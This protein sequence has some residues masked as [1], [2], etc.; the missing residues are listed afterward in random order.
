VADKSSQIVLAALSQAA[1]HADG[2]PLHGS[3][4]HPGLFPATALGKQAAQRCRD[5]GFL[6]PLAE[7]APA[8]S[9][10]A[11][12]KPG[13]EPWTLTDKGMAYLLNQV[14]P[15]HVLED[16]VRALE[17]RRAPI[18]DL[19]VAARTM[20]A[21]LE[22]LKSNAEKVLHLFP[23]TGANGS[24]AG[25]S[26]NALFT[27]FLKETRQATPADPAPSAEAPPPCGDLLEPLARWQSTSGA[28]EDCPLPELFRQ[29][30]ANT[31]SLSIGVFH[32]ELRRLHD[33]GRIYLH[34]WTGP[35]YE[36]PEPPYALLVGHEIAY[37]ASLRV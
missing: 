23:T 37:Y 27:Q 24:P 26:L 30:Q 6:H 14:S 18:S 2:L 29:V 10:P 35:L 12:K 25:G 22:S 15:R 13:Q 4:A 8:D 20:Q 33:A 3:K 7:G 36:L 11:G 31:P 16:F 21:T 34:P 19:L 28:A 17:T 32:D 1:A 5:E 9:P